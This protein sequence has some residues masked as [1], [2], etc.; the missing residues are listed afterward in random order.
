VNAY[1]ET[2]ATVEGTVLVRARKFR[3]LQVSDKELSALPQIDDAVRQIQAPELVDDAVQV[4]P[5][6]GRGRK[7]QAPAAPEAAELVRADPDL[8]ALVET[9]DPQGF[10]SWTT[11]DVVNAPKA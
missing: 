3:D 4:E 5:M 6:V 2:V 10:D 7:K 1:N 8:L 9:T 11:P